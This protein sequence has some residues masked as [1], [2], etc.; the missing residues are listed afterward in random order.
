MVSDRPKCLDG[1]VPD[2]CVKGGTQLLSGELL[3]WA[4]AA[5]AHVGHQAEDIGNL[6]FTGFHRFIKKTLFKKPFKRPLNSDSAVL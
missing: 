1:K 5:V 2:A 3:E 6:Q 4:E